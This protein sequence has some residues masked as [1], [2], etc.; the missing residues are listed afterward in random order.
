MNN[1]GMILSTYIYILLTFFLLLLGTVLVVLNNTKLLESKLVLSATDITG[2]FNIILVGSKNDV[3]YKGY[4]YTDPGYIAK[5]I[6]GNSLTATVVSTVNTSILG[7][8]TITYTVKYKGITKSVVRNV[9]IKLKSIYGNFT[10][11]VNGNAGV[12]GVD[13]TFVDDGNDNWRIKFLKSGTFTSNVSFSI[14]VF[15]VGGGGGG[16]GSSGNAAGGGGGGYTYTFKNYIL[17]ANKAYSIVVGN[18]GA[19]SASGTASTAF[20]YTAAGGSGGITNG[21]GGNGGSGGGG[22][23]NTTD[24]S[25]GGTDGGNGRDGQWGYVGGKGQNSVPGPNGE[26]GNTREFGESAGYIYSGGGA[27][28]AGYFTSVGGVN[29]GG[30][31][32]VA[33]AANTGGGGGAYSSAYGAV[34]GSGIVIIRNK[35]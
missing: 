34:G 15:L 13:Y 24:T 30:N 6:N 9:E 28:S 11:I 32:G 4:A 22:P 21:N 17:L 16:G 18:G 35:R 25:T 2:E 12:S 5:D 14:D 10:Y 7:N 3:A 23:G 20:G 1:K 31:Y 8:Y 26:T 27:G 29:G 33:G 19:T